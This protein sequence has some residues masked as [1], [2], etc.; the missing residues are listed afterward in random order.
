MIFESDDDGNL[1]IVGP[2]GATHV[3]AHECL[4]D[5]NDECVRGDHPTALSECREER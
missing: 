5:E 1:T 4:T 2:N 3:D